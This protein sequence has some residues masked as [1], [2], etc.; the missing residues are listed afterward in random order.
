MGNLRFHQS[1]TGSHPRLSRVLPKTGRGG[2]LDS[3]ML[4]DIVAG[5]INRIDPM[6]IWSVEV[7]TEVVLITKESERKDG[8]M[9]GK[10]EGKVRGER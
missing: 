1:R 9:A 5:G 3:G 4:V 6:R 7:K 10:E 2:R 8:R